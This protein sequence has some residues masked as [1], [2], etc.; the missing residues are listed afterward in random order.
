MEHGISWKQDRSVGYVQ[1][2]MISHSRILNNFL[3]FGQIYRKKV[4][5]NIAA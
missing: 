3:F 4:K 2:C 1:G 5:W